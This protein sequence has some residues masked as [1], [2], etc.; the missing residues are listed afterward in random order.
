MSL[1]TEMVPVKSKILSSSSQHANKYFD[2]QIQFN[3]ITSGGFKMKS[4]FFKLRLLTAREEAV[5]G[6]MNMIGKKL[7][8]IKKN[9]TA[10]AGLVPTYEEWAKAS[11]LQPKELEN[12]IDLTSQARNLLVIHNIRLV[13]HIVRSI[14]ATSYHAK[15]ISYFEMVTEGIVGLI[16][17]AENFDGRSRFITFAP[18]FI[19]S[20]ILQ[21]VTRL[22]PGALLT[23][24]EAI[25]HNRAKK[26]QYHLQKSLQRTPTDEE[27][28]KSLK[29][30]VS[31]LQ[32]LRER[33]SIRLS[34][35][36]QPLSVGS[37]SQSESDG[38]QN[39]YDMDLIPEEVSSGDRLLW[40]MN[41]KTALNCLDPAEKRVIGL[42]FGLLDGIPKSITRTA[43]LMCITEEGARLTLLRAFEKLR[44]SPENEVLLNGPPE[45]AT[46]TLSNKISARHY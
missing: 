25:Y 22:Q 36:D 20:S 1:T 12:Y 5:L 19:R 18:V 34:S 45:S 7:E 41:F 39:Y 29:V 6:K 27:I 13:D 42:R 16:K 46:N 37:R 35:A 21:A 17:A 9:I 11:K 23:H 3:G 24:R 31:Y 40:N 38:T 15:K 30:P 8:T 32:S 43:E 10:A 28:A 26:I 44:S 14:M 33:A 2:G 4:K